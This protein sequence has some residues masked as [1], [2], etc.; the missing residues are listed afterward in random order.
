MNKTLLSLIVI[1]ILVVAGFAVAIANQMTSGPSTED[2]SKHLSGTSSKLGSQTDL[3]AQSEVKIDIRNFAYATPNIKI[4]KGT[5]VTWT[6]HDATKHN[7]MQSHEDDDHSH[8]APSADAIVDNVFAGPL[9]AKNES[10]S[11][12]FNETGE[13]SYHCAPHPDMQGLVTVVD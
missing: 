2:K 4:K 6:N 11:F 13:F 1:T 9:L 3:T 5:K 7:A 12:T 10:Y 8:D